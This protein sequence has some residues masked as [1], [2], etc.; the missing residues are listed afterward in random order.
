MA[1]SWLLFNLIALIYQIR[2]ETDIGGDAVIGLLL[3]SIAGLAVGFIAGM[4]KEQGK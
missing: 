4:D 3:L 2:G 1:A